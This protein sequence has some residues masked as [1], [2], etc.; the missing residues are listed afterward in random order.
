MLALISSVPAATVWTLLLTFPAAAE[1]GPA[2][3]AVF[4]ALATICS[5]MAASSSEAEL[6]PPELLATAD[7]ASLSP[8]SAD[9][10]TRASEFSFT[11]TDSGPKRAGLDP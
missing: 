7:M 11:P 1:T 9:I 3:A 4:S 6:R 8:V 10:G 5:L 2:W